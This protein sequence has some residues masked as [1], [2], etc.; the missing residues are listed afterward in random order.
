[1]ANSTLDPGSD[2]QKQLTQLEASIANRSRL[3]RAFVAAALFWSAFSSL[4]L[5]VM[6]FLTAQFYLRFRNAKRH[7]VALDDRWGAG[8]PPSALILR[9]SDPYNRFQIQSG[10]HEPSVFSAP[11]IDVVTVPDSFEANTEKTQNSIMQ[12]EAGHVG[13][14]D[15][16]FAFAGIYVFF[17]FAFFLTIYAMHIFVM[18][19]ETVPVTHISFTVC[20][21]LGLL[22][23]YR[24]IHRREYLA[25]LH[26]MKSH[27]ED[28]AS[29]R[30]R[31]AQ[32]EDGAKAESKLAYWFDFVF[33]PSAR[34]RARIVDGEAVESRR[35]SFL[36]AFFW[37]YAG[38][39]VAQQ[40]YLPRTS[41]TFGLSPE[42]AYQP[43]YAV[44]VC[45]MFIGWVI[46]KYL[47]EEFSITKRYS[48][49]ATDFI[50][51]FLGVLAS[52]V[53]FHA[54]QTVFFEDANFI[55]TRYTY[56]A[57]ISATA[58]HFLILAVLIWVSGR[59]N[60]S[61]VPVSL[62]A[63]L[64]LIIPT[65]ATYYIDQMRAQVNLE[66]MFEEDFQDGLSMLFL[67]LKVQTTAILIV[68]IAPFV[69]AGVVEK[70]MRYV[71]RRSA[72]AH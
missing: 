45:S 51:M 16:A 30:R 18:K 40:L 34:K 5:F 49:Y 65:L 9:Q 68:C 54:A 4:A 53:Y 66:S 33:H 29:F 22:T 12:H 8:I 13:K 61:S 21:I 63:T 25:D 26:A 27:A 60:F 11:L 19:Y 1:M 31:R 7:A 58:T 64:V 62:A 48:T 14:W 56:L 36:Y 43:L 71:R 69:V 70:L 46:G 35:S 24:T 15:T 72:N 39:S 59:L 37:S 6:L 32:Y 50:G 41:F 2:G 42:D 17:F 20:G 3:D 67:Y 47:S 28:Y 23:F 52:I 55:F 57:I 10:A 38:L 44:V